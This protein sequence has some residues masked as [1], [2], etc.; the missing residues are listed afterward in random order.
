MKSKTLR[1]LALVILGIVFISGCIQQ[2]PVL[3][4]TPAEKIPKGLPSEESPAEIPEEGQEE[5][6]VEA[7]ETELPQ[8]LSKKEI[9]M[10]TLSANT[11]SSKQI[12]LSW[13][14]SGDA[15]NITN[16]DIRRGPAGIARV[17][18]TVTSYS[19]TMTLPGTDYEYRV[20]AIDAEGKE[21]VSNPAMATTL[22]IDPPPA[23][24]LMYGNPN[25]G[26]KI[27][28][29]EDW[30]KKESASSAAF[31]FSEKEGVVLAV[32]EIY[33][34]TTLDE[35]TDMIISQAAASDF[36]II[37]SSD[38]TFANNPARKLVRTKELETSEEQTSLLILTI[39]GNNFY[40]LTYTA[41]SDNYAKHLDKVEEMID[42]FE[43]FRF[44]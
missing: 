10:I 31:L 11:V 18:A 3:E 7:P 21:V 8:A 4:K 28:Y 14:V 29:P 35:Y 42:S 13:E 39:I 20:V 23:G 30:T 41:K 15:T 44:D 33:T 32:S 6:E 12:D 24:F 9:L 37:E 1:I 25:Y 40:S 43:I 36:N 16:Y 34:P 38:T 19:D 27:N 2:K 26:I 17:S 5:P 22:L